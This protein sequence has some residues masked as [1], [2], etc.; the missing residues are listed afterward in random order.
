MS[1]LTCKEGAS[2]IGVWLWSL[3]WLVEPNTSCKACE[4]FDSLPNMM[5]TM[6]EV[7]GGAFVKRL[8][9]G[10]VREMDKQ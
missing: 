6:L 4:G 3:S 7:E 8:C 1:V 2:D 10:T 5:K 9:E